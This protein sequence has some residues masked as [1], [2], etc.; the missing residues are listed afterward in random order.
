MRGLLAV[1]VFVAACSDGDR[2]MPGDASVGEDADASVSNNLQPP[3]PPMIVCPSGWPETVLADGHRFCEPW[4]P[5]ED[6]ACPAGQARFV[7]SSSCTVVGSACP[8]GDLPEGLPA[9]RDV[10]F[11]STSAPAVGRDGTRERPFAGLGEAFSAASG[12]EIFA[13]GKGR[14][15]VAATF[16]EDTTLWG[17]CTA[18]TELVA[19]FVDDATGTISAHSGATVV[20]QNLSIFGAQPGFRVEE[21]ATLNVQD[22]IVSGS[23]LAGAFVLDG[24]FVADGFVVRDSAPRDGQFGR[25]LQVQGGGQAEV[26]RAVFERVRDIAV[27]VVDSESSAELSDVAI[28][29]VRPDGAADLGRGVETGTGAALVLSRAVIEDVRDTGVFVG[30]GRAA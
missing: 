10:I 5:D 11:V 3:G 22:V 24:T 4:A 15:S 21:R 30:G 26:S 19:A 12:G 13:L 6:T 8:E 20:V 16:P 2:G 14:H 25:G 27:Q 23:G 1:M 18:E 7:G 29:G 9:D 28:R 17:A